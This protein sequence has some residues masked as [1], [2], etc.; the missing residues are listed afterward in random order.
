M[1]SR[2]TGALLALCVMVAGCTSCGGGGATPAAEPVTVPQFNHDR[3]FADLVAQ[4]DFGPRAPGSQGHREC[5]AWLKQ[6]LASASVLVAQQFTA[7]TDFGGPYDFTNLIALYGAGQPGVPFLLCAHWDTRPVADEDPDPAKQQQPVLGANDGASGVAVLLE[8]ARLLAA[9]PPPRPVII[10]LFDAEDS[11]TSA[12]QRPWHGFCIGS[13]YLADNWPDEIPRPREGALLDLVG[14]DN[15]PNPACPP[16]FGGNDYLDFPIEQAS[17]E[18]NP[19]LIDRIWGIAEQR[20]HTAFVRRGGRYV[21]DDHIPLIEAGIG[22][23]DIIDFVPP[24]WHTTYDTPEHC[25]PQALR[26]VGDT[27]AHFIY[28]SEPAA[29]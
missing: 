3:A 14:G 11:G 28:G 9:S 8:M 5:L 19:T 25:S 20:G 10:A 1:R 4:C 22:V 16:R 27:L 24:E 2:L 6:Q 21:I 13:Q 29:P 26:Q 23:I 12:S 18:A 17:L 15:L 7:D